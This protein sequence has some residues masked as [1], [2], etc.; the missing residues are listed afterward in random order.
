MSPLITRFESIVFD[1]DG[2]LVDSEAPALETF[3]KS[4]L[5]FNLEPPVNVYLEALG[6]DYAQGIAHFERELQ[7]LVPFDEFFPYW[8]HLYRRIID[9]PSLAL[10]PGAGELL[11]VLSSCGIPLAVATSSSRVG[12]D[13][14]LHNTGIDKYFVCVVTGDDVEHAKPDPSIYTLALNKVGASAG[15]SLALEDSDNGVRA[16]VAAGM[17]V[18][19][20]PGIAPAGVASQHPNVQV[21]ENLH[22]VLTHLGM[23]L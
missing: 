15:V 14:K 17:Q 16:A 18:F 23:P 3:K 8:E 5:K 19:H 6:L 1:L 20:M 21:F 11:E 10:M 12:A 13:Q 2:L 7:G 22:G 9:S 4:C